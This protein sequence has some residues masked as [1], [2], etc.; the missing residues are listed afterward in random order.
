MLISLVLMGAVLALAAHAA[1][2]QL[3]FFVGVSEIVGVRTQIGHASAVVSRALWGISPAA[4]DIIVAMD[5]ALE[6]HAT[7]GSA[8]VCQ[9]GIGRATIAA[10]E[11]GHGNALAAFLESPAAGD[12]VLVFFDDSLG[13]G[14]LTLNVATA[15]AAGGTC[16][17]FPQV[18][19]TWTLELRE[20]VTLP[21]GAA[22]RFSRPLRLS[23]YRGTDSK[24][25]LGARDWNGESEQFNST[26]PV[27]GPLRPYSTNRDMTGFLLTFRDAA[28][29]VLDAPVDA[30]RIASVAITS[31]ALSL[32]PVK[33]WGIVPPT[34][35]AFGDSV[36]VAI[37]PRN[38]R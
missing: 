25:Y 11:Q 4:G 8:V 31:R 17:T 2:S 9:A 27:A 26:Q 24:W 16:P 28:G 29:A 7:I 38:A 35:E 13:T 21:K 33:V 37:S 20:P 19:A 18:A 1:L 14:W 10:P 5:S 32:R 30:L 3:R 12:R 36:S 23:L 22:L 15:P 34:A 6:I